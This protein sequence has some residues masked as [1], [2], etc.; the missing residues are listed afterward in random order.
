[1][2][3]KPSQKLSTDRFSLLWLMMGSALIGFASIQPSYPLAAWLAPVF[4]LRFVRSQP[5]RRGLLLVALGQCIALAINWYIGTSPNPILAIPG[6]I[7]GLLYT[8]GYAVDRLVAPRL[9]GIASALI[10]PLAMTSMDWVDSQFASR[11]TSYLLPSLFSV[12]GSWNSP[13]Y[14]QTNLLLLQTVAL[15]GMWGLTFL[16]TFFAS[17][18]NA[19]W[20]NGFRQGIG[21]ASLISFSILFTTMIIWGGIRL[22]VSAPPSPSTV[23]V[24]GIASSEDLFATIY[25]VNPG[26][27]MPGTSSQRA[28]ANARFIPI[29]DD[30]FA[31]TLKESQ[32]GARI[33]TWGETGSPIIE[34]QMPTLIKRASDMAREEQIYLQIGVI[35]FRNTDHYPFLENR[36]ILFDPTGTQVWDYH[37]AHPTP[38]ENTMVAAGPLVIPTVDTP[39]GRLATVIC[40]DMDFPELIRQAGQAKV[41]ILLAPYKDWESVSIQHA[42][43]AT[44]RAIENGIWIVRPSLSG[45]STI[46]DPQGTVVT[47]TSA[48]GPNEPTVVATIP[49][50]H[51]QTP[52]AV[53]GDV[54][55]YLCIFALA[56]LIGKSYMQIPKLR[57]EA[58]PMANL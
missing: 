14:S 2:L 33:I 6:I 15:T 48:F 53:F 30:L 55:A 5:V 32:A 56:G 11:L 28:N 19:L 22:N 3:N 44:F 16:I 7:V 13:G 20:E 25:D 34:E 38:G 40:Y 12:G 42:Q 58:K 4:L 43:M 51:R 21:R 49:T 1:M 57:P 29:A 46:V 45:I 36:V 17:T 35:V 26:E 50:R 31:R 10:F 24:A 8:C 52:Y 23:K 9:Q 47:Q 37:K 39:Y 41:D 27:L 54:F 18:V